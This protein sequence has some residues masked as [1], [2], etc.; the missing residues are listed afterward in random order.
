M[1]TGRTIE[2]A[3]R[4]CIRL[5]GRLLTSYRSSVLFAAIVNLL[6]AG[7]AASVL[8]LS[9]IQLAIPRPVLHSVILGSIIIILILIIAYLIARPIVKDRL[10]ERRSSLVERTV[11][12][13][14]DV[15][16][17]EENTRQL[18]DSLRPIARLALTLA[19]VFSVLPILT[20]VGGVGVVYLQVKL[21]ENQNN[22]LESQTN[23]V[24]SQTILASNQVAFDAAYFLGESYRFLESID[25][26]IEI[27]YD[28]S[29]R[30]GNIKNEISGFRYTSPHTCADMTGCS[31]AGAAGVD[32]LRDL[33]LLSETI[34]RIY[35]ELNT[36][37]NTNLNE[38]NSDWKT[39]RQLLHEAIL[40]CGVLHDPTVTTLHN[41]YMLS[42][43]DHL[44][45]VTRHAKRIEAAWDDD[46]I[47]IEDRHAHT[48]EHTRE[49][50][51]AMSDFEAIDSRFRSASGAPPTTKETAMAAKP[52]K[53]WSEVFKSG[54]ESLTRLMGDLSAGQ[55][56]SS[57][58]SS[59]WV[60][61][62]LKEFRFYAYA[63][64][65]AISDVRDSEVPLPFGRPLAEQLRPTL[66]MLEAGQSAIL[67]GG[68]RVGPT[69]DTTEEKHR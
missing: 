34:G 17:K 18:L 61:D 1:A 63:Y 36:V 19:L 30:L 28:Y 62:K 45:T 64:L 41:N 16:S 21:L 46:D 24:K 3:A 50:G 40:V 56:G 38:T 12:F 23:V 31:R 37:I 15:G 7:S 49:L 39:S 2:R 55:C 66:D 48:L 69:P 26:R 60:G 32:G 52:P 20:S 27:M 5:G 59:E 58:R 35:D 10:H 29:R 51:D 47:V 68:I 25:R 22:I 54:V 67:P 53:R 14:S 13:L 6:V 43:W 11:L 44:G 33:Y 65:G 4:I 42:L 8:V 9:F 57:I